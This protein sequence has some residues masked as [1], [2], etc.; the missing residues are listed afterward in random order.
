MIYIP[1]GVFL[2]G[3][4]AHPYLRKQFQQSPPLHLAATGAYLIARTEVTFADW[5]D[6]LRQLKGDERTLRQQDQPRGAQG[7]VRLEGGPTRF[8]LVLHPATVEYEAWEDEPLRYQGRAKRERVVWERLPASGIPFTNAVAYA[9]WLAKTGRVPNARLCSHAE[10]ERAARGADA[11]SF[12]H[13]NAVQPDD[14]NFDATYGRQDPSFGP[15]EVGSYPASQSPFGVHDLVGNALEWVVGGN[16]R[17][18][19]SGVRGGSWYHGAPSAEIAN[20]TD[21]NADAV[22]AY[23]GIRICADLA[24]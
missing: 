1:P 23:L 2:T 17:A 18:P 14:A 15:D 24:E 3:S 10:W 19:R 21:M 13:G 5:L 8:R 20:L 7:T 16:R 9:E 4:N 6:Y 11:R 12:P 22:H